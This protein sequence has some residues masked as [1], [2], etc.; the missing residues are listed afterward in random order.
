MRQGLLLVLSEPGTT[1]LAE[2][3]D[4]YDHEHAPAR[5]AFDGIANATRLRATD[6]VRQTWL[7][8][9]DVDLAV[10]D[11]PDYRALRE[12]RSEREQR[13][14]AGLETFERRTYELVDETIADPSS[15]PETWQERAPGP[16]VVCVSLDVPEEVEAEYHA[17]YAEEHVP[18]LHAIDGW[19]RTRRF[20]LLDGDA[21]RLL[22]VHDLESEAPFAD[23]AY[24]H[25]TSTPRRNALM[26]QVT[27]RERRVFAVHRRFA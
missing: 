1:P 21:P 20:R 17:W 18:L 7:A 16:V 10:L 25:A 24:G 19:T 22:A 5:A 11:R 26:D 6:G 9:Y 27:R 4:W 3:H 12:H 14:I 15:A 2:F 8:T 13:V 23:P